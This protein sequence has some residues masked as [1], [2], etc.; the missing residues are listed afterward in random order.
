[1]RIGFPLLSQHTM[2]P[3][4]LA[5]ITLIGDDCGLPIMQS[6]GVPSPLSPGD[7]GGSHNLVIGGGNRFTQA[8]FG[9]LVT[10]ER[11]TIKSFG[12]SVSGGFN[13]TASDLFASVSGGVQ[14]IA[15]GRFASVSGG[16]R[17]GAGPSSGGSVSGGYRSDPTPPVSTRPWID[18]LVPNSGAAGGRGPHLDGQRRE[19]RG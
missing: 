13:N 11:N 7:R 3:Q 19:L 18:S 10:G 9:G 17:N 1:L 8:A 5:T 16:G 15:S 6:A 12:A 4:V 14:N 2:N